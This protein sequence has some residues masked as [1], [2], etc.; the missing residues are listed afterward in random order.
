MRIKYGKKIDRPCG[1]QWRVDASQNIVATSHGEFRARGAL[2]L[3]IITLHPADF[4]R[5]TVEVRAK[6]REE[7][8]AA[9]RTHPARTEAHAQLIEAAQGGSLEAINELHGTKSG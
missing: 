9:D 6:I 8:D 3:A 2:P 4:Q 5:M 7:L 1:P